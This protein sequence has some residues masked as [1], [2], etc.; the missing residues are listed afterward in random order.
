MAEIQVVLRTR[1]ELDGAKRA[2]TALQGQIGAAKALGKEY[3]HLESQAH[4]AESVIAQ[5]RG[6]TGLRGQLA[7]GLGAIG[8]GRAASFVS[9]GV[10]IG[11]AA[12]GAGSAIREFTKA[13]DSVARLDAALA[14]AGLLT[15]SYRKKLM[16]LAGQL[17]ETTAISDEDWLDA[18]RKLTQFG[19]D[20]SNIGSSIEMVK[21]LAGIL[22]GD[23]NNAATLVSRALQGNFQMFGRYGITLDATASKTEKLAQL[24]RELALRGM[25]QLEA[26]ATTLGGKFRLLRQ[27]LGDLMESLGGVLSRT[28]GFQWAIEKLNV[29][30]STWARWLNLG[31]DRQVGLKNATK[32]TTESIDESVLAK[33][34]DT[35]AARE[36]SAAYDNLI[37]KNERLTKQQQELAKAQLDRALAIVDAEEKA[38]LLSPDSASSRRSTLK[39]SFAASDFA[40]GQSGLR[41]R[42]SVEAEAFN[43]ATT[44][45]E[46]ARRYR[47][48]ERL[49]S[50]LS[51]QGRLF[52][53]EQSTSGIEAA[54]EQGGS[55][56]LAGAL[57]QVGGIDRDTQRL[58]AQI[59][60]QQAMDKKAFQRW[61]AGELMRARMTGQWQKAARVD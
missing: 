34:S 19:A 30:A 35:K 1:A 50:D 2:L 61:V 37:D 39:R 12:L 45:E 33:E 21:N 32:R 47:N 56:N 53:I 3:K 55:G 13:E 58:L 54:T 26:S 23:L 25:G 36:Q 46:R 44:P 51:H 4:R 10:G 20:E 6:T 28:W 41:G 48:I 15:E 42:L 14:R 38:G 11:A 59:I 57:R 9:G 29:A 31:I 27:N 7:S 5:S 17:Q 43:K 60:G 40:T 24:Q 8:L 49:D 52:G 18:L 22:D 16:D